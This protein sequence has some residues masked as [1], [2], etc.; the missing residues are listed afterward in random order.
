MRP[1]EN[2]AKS[3]MVSPSRDDKKR[4][5]ESLVKKATDEFWQDSA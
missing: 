3:V 5:P 2:K 4:V 1:N